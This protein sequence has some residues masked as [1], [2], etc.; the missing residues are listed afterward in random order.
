MADESKPTGWPPQ[1]EA[2]EPEPTADAPADADATAADA[3]APAASAAAAPAGAAIKMPTDT[4]SR[5]ILVNGLATAILALVGVVLGAWRLE[6]FGAVMIVVGLV[7]AG[8]A[9]AVSTGMVRSESLPGRDIELAAGIVAGVLGVLNVFEMV[10]DLDD[11]DDRGGIVGVVLTI[12]LA[13]VA[14]A[15]FAGA[16]RRWTSPR[17]ILAN[18]DRGTRLAYAGVGLVI[19]GWL[20]NVTLGI[21]NFSA[22]VGV[23]TLI[24]L[25]GVVLRWASD[26]AS[27]RLP[28]AGAWIAVVLAVVAALLGLQHLTALMDRADDIGI[29][30]WLFL[31][32]ALAGVALTLVGAVW[33]AYERTMDAQERS[34]VGGGDVS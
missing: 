5:V 11:L 19:L 20:G 23:L 16:V 9:W 29:D 30:D 13:V 7:A 24:L 15:L 10:F 25:A 34:T 17:E 2:P 32:A 4:T 12:A 33:T 21:W 18:G 22:G 14:L 8:V 3:T 6:L 1:G 27:K 28:V 26:P 31:L